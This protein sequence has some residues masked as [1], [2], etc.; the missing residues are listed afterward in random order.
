MLDVVTIGPL[1]SDLLI[2]GTAPS[3]LAELTRWIGPSHIALT[4]AGSAGYVVQALAR[5]GLTAGV[6]SVLADDALG[7][8]I[9]A[10]LRTA[11]VDMR[12]VRRE[13]GTLSG[14]AVYMLLFGSKKGPMTFRLP[15]HTPW[16]LV[17]DEADRGYV[18]DA[19]HVHCGGYL[20]FPIMWTGQLA[21]LYREAKSHGLSTSLDPQK[22]IM[23]T[24][25]SL[26]EVLAK[27][28]PFTD[29]LMLDDDEARQITQTTDIFSAIRLL[30]RAGASIVA[31]KRGPDG[32]LIGVHDRI[33]EQP[34]TFVPDD[35]IVESIG[36]GDAFDAG[37]IVGY[38]ADWPL[39]QA[40]RFAA[41]AAASTLRGSGG[42]ESLATREELER[43]MTARH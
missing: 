33:F 36:A 41:L 10:A 24:Q 1:N 21:D 39:E 4:A 38:L 42:T 19:R 16:P 29:L 23:P 18:F 3:S 31:V 7:D 28:L 6:V 17:L 13:P 9:Q 8:S 43:L 34:A 11:G 14:L 15:T 30:R 5:L 2:T 20:H 40:A 22:L 27:V 35:Q 26:F 32:A 37:L 25:R 12:R